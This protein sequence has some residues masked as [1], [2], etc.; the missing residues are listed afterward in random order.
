MRRYCIL[1]HS[2]PH[3]CVITVNEIHSILLEPSAKIQYLVT[4]MA[5]NSTI[6]HIGEFELENESILAYLERVFL[7]F[8]AISRDSSRETSYLAF[9]QMQCI[10]MHM[11]RYCIRYHMSVWLQSMNP[12]RT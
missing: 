5:T 3:V 12:P 1:L 8:K 9:E 7:F 2:L 6:G 10:I 4:R 11:C